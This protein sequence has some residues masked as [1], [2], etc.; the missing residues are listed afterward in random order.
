MAERRKITWIASI[1][2]RQPYFLSQKLP[3]EIEWSPLHRFGSFECFGNNCSLPKPRKRPQC[4][5]HRCQSVCGKSAARV[6]KRAQGPS[7]GESGVKPSFVSRKMVNALALT[8]KS[9]HD[10]R[11]STAVHIA[12]SYIQFFQKEIKQSGSQLSLTP[13]HL[14]FL[15]SI[16]NCV[17]FLFPPSMVEEVF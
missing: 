1:A 11:P 3:T 14:L 5:L 9:P 16:V 15:P 8:W 6:L 10:D 12:I 4:W 7:E 13:P 2:S 17:V